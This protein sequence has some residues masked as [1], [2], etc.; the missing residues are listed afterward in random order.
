MKALRPLTGEYGRKNPG[1]RFVT[2]S[3]HA[4]TLAAK[5]LAEYYYPPV[6]AMYTAPKPPDRE[7]K[8]IVPMPEPAKPVFR[9]QRTKRRETRR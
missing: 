8:V 2:N 1:E 4:E 9:Q 6:E 3:Q 7:T 5:G